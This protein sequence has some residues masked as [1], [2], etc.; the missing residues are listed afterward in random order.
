MCS[1]F[2]SSA[3]HGDILPSTYPHL[4]YLPREIGFISKALEA[5][6]PQYESDREKFAR[7]KIVLVR[8][9]DIGNE[10]YGY[11]V[12]SADCLP[13]P[14]SKLHEY[15][16]ME[17]IDFAYVAACVTP[18]CRLSQK[19]EMGAVVHSTLFGGFQVHLAILRH[20]VERSTKDAD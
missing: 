2:D 13:K 7:H 8:S 19:K 20:A 15:M 18:R 10:D 12:R 4:R 9:K 14:D 17:K 16:N 1:S 3:H 5:L 11:V 6:I